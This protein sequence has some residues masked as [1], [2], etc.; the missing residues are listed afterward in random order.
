MNY[1]NIGQ[2][3]LNPDWAVENCTWKCT[4][5]NFIHSKE[6]DLPFDNWEDDYTNSDSKT[7]LRFWQGFFRISTE[8]PDSY[9]KQCNVCNRILPFKAFS[10]HA[11][12]GPLERQM[13]C[14]SC[15][16]A[17][18]AVLNPKRTKQQLHES[19]VRRRIADLFLEGQNQFIKK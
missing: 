17:I 1:V 5:C 16:G 15:K 13:E 14:R 9:W 11:K 12:W 19:A 3:L 18:N 2:T 10:K 6:T 7:A 4:S 8:H